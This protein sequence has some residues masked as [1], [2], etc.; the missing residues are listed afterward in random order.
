MSNLV[1]DLPN[2]FLNDEDAVVVLDP[3]FNF[4][5]PDLKHNGIVYVEKCVVRKGK[6]SS[7]TPLTSSEIR[8]N[9]FLVK[10]TNFTDIGGGLQTFEKHYA[11]MPTTWFEYAQE[12]YRASW[13]GAINFRS[14]TGAGDSWSVTRSVAAK[15]THYYIKKD[16]VPSVSTPDTETAGQ[17]YVNDFTKL[18]TTNPMS[19]LGRF[20]EAEL[21]NIGQTIVIAPDEI[22]VYIGDI[23]ELVRYTIE[24]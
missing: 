10:E 8:T 3:N 13:W 15:A 22:G 23:Y 5:N 1:Y 16:D 20:W 7:T 21:G 18:Y 2:S 12:N 19:K 11:T 9:A 17:D 24:I 4:Y 14:V 6:Y